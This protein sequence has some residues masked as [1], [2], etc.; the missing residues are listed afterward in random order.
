MVK[1]AQI[2]QFVQNGQ[3]VQKAT[4]HLS[5]GMKNWGKSTGKIENFCEKAGAWLQ[6]IYMAF[7]VLEK[8]T[9]ELLSHYLFEG[10]LL[11]ANHF[12]KNTKSI[13]NYKLTKNFNNFKKL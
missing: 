3:V 8:C 1:I 13:K 5:V 4:R 11:Q 7:L 12:K 2:V 10:C 6:L 9:P